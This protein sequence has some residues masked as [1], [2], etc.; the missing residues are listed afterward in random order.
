M[1]IGNTEIKGFYTGENQVIGFYIGTEEISIGGLELTPETQS[2]SSSGGSFTITVKSSE[3]WTLSMDSTYLSASIYSGNSGESAVTITV[4]GNTAST[5]VQTTITATTQNYTA[6]TVVSIE[7]T[8]DYSSRYLTIKAN[9]AGNI[10]WICGANATP[11][12]IDYSKDNGT[13]WSSITATTAGSAIP[14]NQGDV[15]LFKGNNSRYQQRYQEASAYRNAFSI[16]DCNVEVEGNIMSMIYGDNFIGNYTLSDFSFTNLFFRC[17][18]ITTCE[19]LILP[20]TAITISC[21]FQMFYECT[22]LTKAPEL[23]AVVLQTHSYTS[24]FRNCTSLNYIKCL[25]SRFNAVDCTYD[26]V[27]NVSSTGTFVKPS[28]MTS[29][30]I[31]VNGIPSGWTV[32]DA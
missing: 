21:Y 10:N 8:L 25:A 18:G 19:N 20:S 6:S 27:N 1:F 2:F 7:K 3:A 28:Q 32:V 30:S 14:V 11:L 26:W 5:D 17:S 16:T 13:T 22:S 24:M 4:A 9:S 23:P 12:S 29:W 31:G 15:V